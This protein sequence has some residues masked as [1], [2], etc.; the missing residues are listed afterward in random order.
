MRRS[1]R[2]IIGGD[3]LVRN[4]DDVGDWDGFARELS[5]FFVFEDSDE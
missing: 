2:L 4:A 1:I 3:G 5:G